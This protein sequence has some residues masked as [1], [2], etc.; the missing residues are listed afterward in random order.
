MVP[1]GIGVYLS[2]YFYANLS[3]EDKR[4]IPEAFAS[5]NYFWVALSLIIAWL[6]HFS[7]AWRWKYMLEPLG[8]KAKVSS[9]YH[10]VM[11]GYIINLTVPRSGEF[12]RA[13]FLSKKEDLPF[14]TVF[15]TIVAERVIDVIMLAIVTFTTYL[16]VGQDKIDEITNINQGTDSFPWL[17]VIIGGIAL[18]GTI[19]LIISPK[20]RGW[21]VSKLK[22][23]WSGVKTVFTLKK[24][25]LYLAHTAFIWVAYVGMFWVCAQGLP[26]VSNMTLETMFACFTV[27]AVAIAITPGGLGFYPAFVTAA[28]MN[29]NPDA[30]LRADASGFAILMWVVQTVFLIAFGLYSLFAIRVKFS[31]KEVQKAEG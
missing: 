2:W 25:L 11:I 20:I 14:E 19:V 22:G 10:S 1:V 8:F 30:H 23:L 9:L 24:K 27:G 29:V 6:S 5:A 18:A 17:Y 13:G 12:A 16:L 31:S 7:R 4:G 15:G 26:G 28:L 3:E 21:F